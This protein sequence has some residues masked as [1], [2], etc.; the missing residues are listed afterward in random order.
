VNAP[1]CPGQN[2]Q[3]WNFDALY[4]IPCPFC[5]H[6][7]EFWKDEPIRLCPKCGEEVRNPKI[8]LGCAKWCPH[9]AE[10]MGRP[11]DLIPD[12]VFDRMTVLLKRQLNREDKSLRFARACCDKAERNTAERNVSLCVVKA[13]ALL[14][15]A[16]RNNDGTYSPIPG[17]R[18]ILLQSGMNP[19]H[20]ETIEAI[21]EAIINGEAEESPEFEIVRSALTAT[22]AQI[23]GQETSK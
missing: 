20:F 23:S 6:E 22:I 13:A 16:T 15:G 4:D 8:D 9:A 18:D 7:I 11:L 19:Q 14:V 1:R 12:S 3:Y 21:I 10:C 17:T 2:Q 5:S